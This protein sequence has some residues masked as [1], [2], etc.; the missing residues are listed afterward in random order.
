LIL[1]RDLD[2]DLGMELYYVSDASV[3]RNRTSMP[4]PIFDFRKGHALDSCFCQS[5]FDLVEFEGCDEC[6]NL[7]HRN[8]HLQIATAHDS[9]HAGSRTLSPHYT[10]SKSCTAS[11]LLFLRL[12]WSMFFSELRSE[13]SALHTMRF[14]ESPP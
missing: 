6:F 9:L 14:T 10:E 7:F 11:A 4:V 2:F 1:D 8:L 12:L 3:E 13:R 5:F